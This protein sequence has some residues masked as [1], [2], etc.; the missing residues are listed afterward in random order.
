MI[1]GALENQT[2]DLSKVICFV[3]SCHICTVLS[4]TQVLVLLSRG[5]GGPRP[6]EATK[7]ELKEHQ[8]VQVRR[9]SCSSTTRGSCWRRKS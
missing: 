3:L 6:A 2:K 5:K 4:P 8:L 1:P 7:D 9:S